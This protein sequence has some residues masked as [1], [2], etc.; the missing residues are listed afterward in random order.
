MQLFCGC[1]AVPPF[2]FDRTLLPSRPDQNPPLSVVAVAYFS[3][4]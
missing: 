1:N 3:M 4:G 2:H